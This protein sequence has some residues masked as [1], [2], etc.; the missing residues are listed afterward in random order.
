MPH[1]RRREIPPIPQGK[2]I[3]VTETEFSIT[4]AS[5]TLSAG[6]YTFKIA[7]NGKFTHN[8]TIDGPGIE[9]KTSPAL[10]AGESGDLTVALQKGSYDFYCSVDSHKEKGMNVTVQV[11]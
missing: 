5:T 3:S 8:L 6:T 2:E 10:A 9:D 4:L 1:H 7:N 11:T